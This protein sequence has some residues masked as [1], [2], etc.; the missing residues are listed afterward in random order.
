MSKK[1][2]P[3]KKVRHAKPAAKERPKAKVKAAKA[4]KPAKP[5]KGAKVETKQVADAKSG[6]KGITIVA[7]PKP[8]R[9]G[10]Q[11][12]SMANVIPSGLGRLLDPKSPRKPLIPSGPKAA[13]GRALGQH[14]GPG[15]IAPPPPAKSQ[16]TA[17][18]MEHFRQL[19]WKKRHELVGDVNMM[20]KEALRSES[21]SLSNMPSHLAEQGSDASEQS[22][23]LDL[24]AAD[25]K[26]IK[27]IDDALLRIEKGTYG[28]CEISG[29]PIKLDRLEELPWAR[30]SIEAARELERHA[31]RS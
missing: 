29:R 17:A 23:S 24:A 5:E 12:I 1:S 30:Y 2:A 4:V 27:E 25:R 31:M 10:K 28:V 11:P 16:L 15:P 9:K 22:L 21:G 6:R 14:G 19:L 7:P 13:T 8:V 26:L 18:Q 3:S 20:E